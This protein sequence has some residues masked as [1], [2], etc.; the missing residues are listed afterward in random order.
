M[1]NSL[2]VKGEPPEMEDSVANNVI[3]FPGET[4]N[5][6]AMNMEEIYRSVAAAKTARIDN[7]I[8]FVI[9]NLFEDLFENSYDFTDRTDANKDMAFLIEAIKSLL[10]KH[11]GLDHPFQILAE[12]YFVADE[13]GDLSFV[14]DTESSIVYVMMD[15]ETEVEE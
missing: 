2:E 1:I 8:E 13:A 5:R 7:V 4:K 12:S 6:P 10:N 3:L 14:E 9:I 11:D 15:D